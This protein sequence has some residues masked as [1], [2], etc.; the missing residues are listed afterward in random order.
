MAVSHLKS[1]GITNRDATPRVI[2][3]PN[4]NGGVL[5]GAVGVCT[6]LAADDIGSTYRF[7]QVP[8]NATMHALRLTAADQGNAG[9]IDIGLY[10]TIADGGAVVDADFFASAVDIN[11]AALADVNV[12]VESAVNTNAKSE[13]PLWQAVG[14]TADPGGF[15]DV[16]A[17][18]TEAS[19]SG[20]EIMLRGT[21]QQ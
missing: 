20:G 13:Q 3:N 17:T 11:A 5:H 19:Q 12:L 4:A 15:F 7:F 1:A 2:A 21:W 16:V 9:D 6:A 18:L 10:K 8:S 14:L